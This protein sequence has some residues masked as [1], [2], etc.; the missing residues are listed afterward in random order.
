MD[1]KEYSGNSLSFLGDAVYTLRVREYFLKEGYQSPGKLQILCNR[2]N[3]AKGQTETW[4]RLK[5][6]SFFTEKEEEI[7][8]RGRNAIRHIPKNGDLMTYETASGLE[9]VC[10]NLYL[11]D[12]ERLEAFFEAVF[13]GEENDE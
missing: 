10:G 9:A 8:K 3:S 6:A 1:L 13:R 5:E 7:F 4:F 11:T 2:M 12:R